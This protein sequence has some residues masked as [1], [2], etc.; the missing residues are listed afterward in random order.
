MLQICDVLIFLLCHF[1]ATVQ[2]IYLPSIV[3]SKIL[4]N[5]SKLNISFLRLSKDTMYNKYDQQSQGNRYPLRRHW[6][7]SNG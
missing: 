3:D 6:T 2:L 4:L 5:Y 1:T 7:P